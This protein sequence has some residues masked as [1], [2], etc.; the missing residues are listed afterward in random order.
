MTGA[1]KAATQ[2]GPWDS[3]IPVFR[4]AAGENENWHPFRIR[5]L[6][7]GVWSLRVPGII[8]QKLNLW[9]FCVVP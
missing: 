1:L 5:K 7:A 2:W 9:R 3:P 8:L 4:G 6:G